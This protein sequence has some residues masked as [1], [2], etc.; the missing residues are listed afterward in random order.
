MTLFKESYVPVEIPQWALDLGFEDM[1]WYNNA[2]PHL[3]YELTTLEVNPL[4]VELWVNY[5]PEH[6]ED[7][8]EDI[9][10]MA[11]L[12]QK[13]SNEVVL[14]VYSGDN[15]E[16]CRLQVDRFITWAKRRS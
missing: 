15:E 13:E 7:G 5:A 8:L 4:I 3:E 9:T 12:R 2:M 6:R 10:Y 11:F 1:S 14:N 16:A